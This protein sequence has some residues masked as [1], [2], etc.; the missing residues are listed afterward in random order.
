MFKYK[1]RVFL[2]WYRFTLFLGAYI[3]AI[4]C[5]KYIIKPEQDMKWIV[6]VELIFWSSPVTAVMIF[7]FWLF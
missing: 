3:T 4:I 7:D 2:L 1:A 5:G 6:D